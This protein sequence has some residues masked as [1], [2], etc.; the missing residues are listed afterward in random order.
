M[1]EL[2][3]QEMMGRW[4]QLK[5]AGVGVVGMGQVNKGRTKLGG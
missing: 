1:L 3:E 5:G 2:E 4:N